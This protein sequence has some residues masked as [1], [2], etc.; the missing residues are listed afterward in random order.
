MD[1]VDNE[2]FIFPDPRNAD[3]SGL[4][5]Y[6]GDLNPQRVLKAYM[7]GIFP[8]PHKDYPLLWF[9]PK[10]RAL[11]YP[12][13][14]KISR[15]FKKSIKKYEVRFDTNFKAV[16]KN[17]ATIKRGDNDTWIDK[18]MIS[19][20]VELFKLGY[21]HSVETYFEG[22]LIGGL[23]GV[24]IGNLF[25]GE[26]MF[27]KR[28]DAS[29][30]ALYELCKLYEKFDGIIDAQIQNDHLKS[31]GVIEVSRDEYLKILELSK[32]KKNPFLSLHVNN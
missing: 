26:S 29:K 10:T 16:I 18:E 3:D 21:A 2:D 22:E 8:W 12:K 1:R 19:S 32:Q 13:N 7:C 31:L 4:L 23:Y 15:S 11:L 30:V 27:S 28:S 9:S 6:G 24:S 17:C 25:C 20:Y 14:L 5:A